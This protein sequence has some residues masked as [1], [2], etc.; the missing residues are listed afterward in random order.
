MFLT[1]FGLNL[2]FHANVSQSF[3]SCKVDEVHISIVDEESGE[4]LS[5]GETTFRRVVKTNHYYDAYSCHFSVDHLRD[6]TRILLHQL[7]DEVT[8]MRV[9]SLNGKPIL[10]P[11]LDT[12][13][14]MIYR[15]EDHV[16]FGSAHAMMFLV[17][18]SIHNSN[19][20]VSISLASYHPEVPVP[21]FKVR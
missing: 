20:K 8:K 18:Y 12:M 21:T 16:K 2:A 9:P 15:I 10:F 3:I 17:D 19:P 6:E 14:G 4:P 7:A 1:E 13:R 5:I 11:D